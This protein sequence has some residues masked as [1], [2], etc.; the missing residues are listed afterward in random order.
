MIHTL[1]KGYV[2]GVELFRMGQTNVLGRYPIHFHL[3]QDDCPGCYFKDSSVHRSFYRCISVHGTNEILV[4]EN[5]GYD[6]IGYCYYLEDGVEERNTFSYNLAA[7]IHFLS[8]PAIGGPQHVNVVEETADLTLP[9]DITASGF[10]ITN[11]HNNIIGNVAVGGWA[12]F[13]VPILKS[14]IGAHKDTSFSPRERTVL[15]FDG[16]T[17]HSTAHFWEKAAAFYFGGSIYY[18]TNGKLEYNAGREKND[19]QRR[20]PCTEEDGV[21]TRAWNRITN[22]KAF[23]VAGVGIGSWSGGMEVLSYECHDCGLAAEAL[24]DGFWIDDMVAACRT[25]EA[26]ILPYQKAD[27]VR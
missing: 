23:L 15:K 9:A 12:G 25:G 13:A 21:C 2:E 1:G 24:V 7:H 4:S 16:N 5:V 22:S 10:Y 19:D 8:Y 27:W 3:L 20:K 11:L 26:L 14:P 17:A 6:V 18:N